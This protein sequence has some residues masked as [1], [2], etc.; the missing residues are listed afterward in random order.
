M[1]PPSCCIVDD[2]G[3]HEG[4][5]LLDRAR[6][7]AQSLLR[8]AQ[9]IDLEEQRVAL[10]CQ[11]GADWVV[12][13]WGIWMAGG[14]AVPLSPQ[15]PPAE[16]QFMLE[17]ADPL[18]LLTDQF[19]HPLLHSAVQGSP[20]ATR[21]HCTIG[22]GDQR[23]G[24]NTLPTVAPSRCALMLYTSGTTG[25]P[26]GVV[27]THASLHAQVSALSAAWEWTHADHALL[28]LPLHHVHG[29]VNAT[30]VPLAVGARLTMHAGF[31]GQ[32][33]WYTLVNDNIT[34]FQAVPTIWARLLAVYDAAPDTTQ[35][36]YRDALRAM[37]LLVSGSAALPV[38]LFNRWRELA[39]QPLLERYGMTEIGMALSNPLHGARA[40]GHVGMPLPTVQVRAVDEHGVPV[41]DGASGELQVR[42]PSVMR[43]YWRRPDDTRSVFQDGWFRT[44]DI[45][46]CEVVDGGHSWRLLGRASTDI[47][48]TG[49]YKVS[50]L[51][52]EEAIRTTM[53][54]R[55]CAVV[56]LADAEWGERV[57]VALE[58]HEAADPQWIASDTHALAAL[59]ERLKS[60]LAVY[61]IPTVLRHVDA[62]PRNV[63]GK[64]Q[65]SQVRALLTS[66]LLTSTLPTSN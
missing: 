4:T 55:D 65:K 36:S 21:S 41:A 38:A 26:K 31:D 30:C 64:V 46:V 15:H 24:S 39:G 50:A 43:E 49:G 37:R 1:I 10:L 7:V 35:R 18:V 63:M 42:G 57:G 8:Q 54:V 27:H 12:G 5:A 40:A 47:I 22:E 48:K 66:T 13:L 59:R 60:V 11:T 45:G 33:V 17:D 19:H 34:V 2:A 61:K 62:L 23:R 52:I 25:K 44:G 28:V 58:W 51:E 3:R 14:M 16:W 20:W 6:A 32:R 56:G 9:C 53:P 29:I